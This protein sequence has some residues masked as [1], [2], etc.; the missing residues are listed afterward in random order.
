MEA[1]VKPKEAGTGGKEAGVGRVNFARPV[2]NG[3]KQ[4]RNKNPAGG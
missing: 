1:G 4:R 2:Q 3:F